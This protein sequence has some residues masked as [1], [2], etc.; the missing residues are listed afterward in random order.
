M[1]AQVYCRAEEQR[2]RGEER[3]HRAKRPCRN[4]AVNQQLKENAMK[5]HEIPLPVRECKVLWKELQKEKYNR[6]RHWK[7]KAIR[8]LHSAGLLTQRSYIGNC[9]FCQAYN[10]FNCPW[11]RHWPRKRITGR[12]VNPRSPY[13]K[14]AYNPN[15]QTARKVY[16]L[17]CR[18]ER[19]FRKGELV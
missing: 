6:K 15:P 10:C 4:N 12:C 3:S 2:S 9:P 19:K 16:Q 14:W 8:E 18:I 5:D 7:A 11:P 17:I 1:A 13:L